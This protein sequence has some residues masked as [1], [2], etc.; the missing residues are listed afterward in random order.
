V[1]L[2]ELVSMTFWL[3][4]CGST[5]G[6]PGPCRTY[7]SAYTEMSPMGIP[8]N[9]TC[10]HAEN[11]GGFDRSCTGG[12]P[13]VEHW[14]SRAD[15]IDEAAAVGIIR[16]AT[17]TSR[18]SDTTT[19]EYDS[20]RRLQRMQ[21]TLSG[22]DDTFDA[23]DD[24]GRPLHRVSHV[25]FCPG[26]EDV[27]ISYGDHTITYDAPAEDL[28]PQHTVH[29]FDADGIPTTIETTSYVFSYVT[30]DRATVCL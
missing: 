27:T 7:A 26:G 16:L 15:F 11:A 5:L 20:Q 24:L 14:A 17:F 9:V 18:S 21:S 12:V 30:M 4:G 19:Y 29:R 22:L 8:V 28:C 13:T 23:W 10:T 3:A 1:A 2:L 6:D 25:A